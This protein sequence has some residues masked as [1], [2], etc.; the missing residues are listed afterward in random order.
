MGN[1]HS[2]KTAIQEKYTVDEVKEIPTFNKYFTKDIV[3][4]ISS[5]YDG[6]TCTAIISVDNNPVKISIRM[7]GYDCPEMK[8]SKSKTDRDFEIKF[9]KLAK[10]KLSDLILN[11]KVLIK[12]DGLDK[13]GRLLGTIYY[14]NK[15]INDYMLS[16]GYGYGYQGDT[17]AVTEYFNDFYMVNNVKYTQARVCV[18]IILNS[19]LIFFH[20]V[21]HTLARAKPPH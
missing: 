12:A 21:L 1:C 7:N 8:P 4:Y 13:Y 17:K 19:N 14:N 3:G 18:C 6:D 9:A 11:K 5:I 15:N 20:F 2:Q 10:E 16:N